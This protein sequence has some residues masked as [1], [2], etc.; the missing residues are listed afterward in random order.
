M[1]IIVNQIPEMK[2]Q[3][4]F[5]QAERCVL[6]CFGICHIKTGCEYLISENAPEKSRG[7]RHMSVLELN[8]TRK[9]RI[10]SLGEDFF[11]R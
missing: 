10:S 3:C 9:T 1:K 7:E 6:D 4:L 5:W 11:E 8:L 2:C